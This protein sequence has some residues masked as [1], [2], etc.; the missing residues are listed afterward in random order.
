MR[1]RSGLRRRRQSEREPLPPASAVPSPARR[2]SS[3][4]AS[5]VPTSTPTG[6]P[7]HHVFTYANAVHR[8]LKRIEGTDRD[9]HFDAERGILHGVMA[10]YLARYINAPP[11]RIPGG[12]G[13]NGTSGLTICLPKRASGRQRKSSA[14]SIL[15]STGNPSWVMD[16]WAIS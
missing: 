16:T 1:L 2:R 10:L 12:G 11:A 4:R 6:R 7:A 9:G 14:S 15:P 3:W 5:A 13:D 8:M